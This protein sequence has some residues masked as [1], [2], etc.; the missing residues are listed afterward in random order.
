[1]SSNQTIQIKKS[2]TSIA[3]ESLLFGELAISTVASNTTLY[4]GDSTGTPLKIYDQSEIDIPVFIYNNT[5]NK[6]VANQGDN[7]N[8]GQQ[9]R[10]YLSIQYGLNTCP[11]SGSVQVESG[12]YTENLTLTTT[13]Q[14]LLGT[15]ATPGINATTRINGNISITGSH[16]NIGSITL[17]N[18][19]SNITINS[20]TGSDFNFNAINVSASVTSTNILTVSNCGTGYIN[21]SN[22]DFANKTLLFSPHANIVF[23]YISNCRNFKINAGANYQVIMDVNSSFVETST[24]NNIYVSYNNC[25]DIISATPV[26]PGLY[27]LSADTTI[28]GNALI[29]GS[30]ISFDG[31]NAKLIYLYYNCPSSIYLSVKNSVYMKTGSLAWSPATTYPIISASF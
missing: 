25:T 8:N 21:I 5:F 17:I 11:S 22:C 28:N 13:G 14:N 7:T 24:N 1:M 10:P 20:T 6:Y 26:S 12:I 15:S 19:S 29:K 3:P 27:L 16:S 23:V 4:A 2:T 31:V 18:T 30:L 9:G